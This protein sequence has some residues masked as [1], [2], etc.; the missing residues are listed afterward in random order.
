MEKKVSLYEKYRW[1]IAVTLLA[2]GTYAMFGLPT[3]KSVFY[4]PMRVS[5]GLTHEQFGR[6]NGIYGKI[7]FL[8]YFPGGW[9]ADKFDARKLLCFSY[10]ASGALGL[11]LATYPSYTGIQLTFMAWGI[12][13]ILTF[14]ATQ[15]KVIRS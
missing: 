5:L 2:F 3:M 4:E 1:L 15:I 9:L 7:C 10:I 11:Y 14:W 6:V 12:T 8:M 13:T